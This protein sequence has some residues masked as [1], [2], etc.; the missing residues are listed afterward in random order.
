MALYHFNA[1][2]LR[3]A[4]AS[5]NLVMVDFWA[6]WCGPCRMLASTIEKL[7]GQYDG[8]VIVGK[9]NTDEE[10]ALAGSLGIMSIPT[11]I[12]F[13]DGREIDRKVGLMPAQ[14]YT[15]VLDANL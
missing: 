8:K 2:G 14:A 9:V 12:F 7:A 11:V 10:S 15:A 3:K 4:V 6:S 5:G 1:D 13:K